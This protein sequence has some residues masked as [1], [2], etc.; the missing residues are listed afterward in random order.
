MFRM[1]AAAPNFKPTIGFSTARSWTH[2]ATT[3]CVVS[4]PRTMILRCRFRKQQSAASH[5][6]EL[7]PFFFTRF[8]QT[9]ALERESCC[10]ASKGCADE[11]ETRTRVEE[12]KS[13]I[14]TEAMGRH[15]LKSTRRRHARIRTARFLYIHAGRDM[16]RVAH[17]TARSMRG[18]DARLVKAHRR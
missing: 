11:M 18:V 17:S 10:P 5:T 9:V 8:L 16:K 14:V 12:S 6:Y 13:A 3:N 4:K 15:G 1:M 2:K 7:G